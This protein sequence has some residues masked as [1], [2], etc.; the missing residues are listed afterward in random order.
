MRGVYGALLSHVA[1]CMLALSTVHTWLPDLPVPCTSPSC[2][3]RNGSGCRPCLVITNTWKPGQW[4]LDRR[5][6]VS[7]RWGFNHWTDGVSMLG[8]G[9]QENHYC[10]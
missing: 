2:S 6:G 4:V 10:N 1:M 9:L 8:E 7:L 3:L 5:P